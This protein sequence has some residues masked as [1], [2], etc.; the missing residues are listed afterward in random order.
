MFRKALYILLTAVVALVV[1]YVLQPLK[2]GKSRDSTNRYELAEHWPQL[3]DSI[4]LG[5]PTGLAMDTSQHLVVFHRAERTWPLFGSMPNDP[6]AS[7]TILIVDPRSGKLLSSWGANL[8]IMP[9]GLQVD[10]DNNIWVTDV[11]LHQV[12]KFSHEGQVLLRLGE[13]GVPGDDSLHFNK[14]TDIAF[15]ADG[16]FYVS[17]GYGNNRVIRFSPE[18]KYLFQWG[19]KGS[20]PGEFDLPHGLATDAAG[21]IYVADR[22]NN[23]IQVFDANGKYLHSRQEESFG[24]ICGLAY[25]E[26]TGELLAADDVSFLKLKH[27]GS[28]ILVFDS[29]GQVRNRFG[30]SGNYPG[31]TAWYHDLTV[32]REGNIF[33]GDILWNRIQQFR[34]KRN[35]P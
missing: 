12:F 23:R 2:K 18:G 28:D 11:G 19:K 27:R 4:E 16:G 6:I 20:G 35:E 26:Q 34:K 14:P 30:R 31:S 33:V 9:H 13:A 17:D 29:S 24:A 10:R 21:N 3:P 15:A 22:E 8:F 25:H 32:D 5:N 7:N 1:A